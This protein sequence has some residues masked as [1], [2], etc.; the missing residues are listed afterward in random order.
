V[1]SSLVVTRKNNYMFSS[2]IAISIPKALRPPR[3][4]P[5]THKSSENRV[6][7]KAK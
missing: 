2:I 4:G 3:L 6:A 5:D 7:Y 1:A